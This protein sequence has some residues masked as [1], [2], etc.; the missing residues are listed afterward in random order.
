MI[1]SE[2]EKEIL[3]N[4]ISGFKSNIK[5]ASISTLIKILP[6]L[7]AWGSLSMLH[8]LEDKLSYPLHELH[9]KDKCMRMSLLSD[10]FEIVNYLNTKNC[11][12]QPLM[13]RYYV[14]SGG[15]NLDIYTLMNNSWNYVSDKD[16][17]T[18]IKNGTVKTIEYLS[19]KIKI[20]E[21]DYS[22]L[23]IEKQKE[24]LKS[25]NIF[26]YYLQNNINIEL[27]LEIL[28][29]RKIRNMQFLRATLILKK[30]VRVVVN[31]IRGTNNFYI[32]K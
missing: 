18:G 26:N 2:I 5:F 24:L 29:E 19:N 27:I 32:I 16:I 17:K 22:N 10:N 4:N 23:P 25:N 13:L 31:K 20:P 9:N 3:S 12:E 1:K 6:F 7:C 11:M 8:L 28:Y 30:F 15:N 21:D 14:C